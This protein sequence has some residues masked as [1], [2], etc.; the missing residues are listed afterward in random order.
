MAETINNIEQN[1][2][3]V[4]VS[5]IK[6]ILEKLYN[7]LPF[8]KNNDGSIVQ[9]DKDGNTTNIT[10]N[11]GEIALGKYNLSDINTVLSLGIG[12]DGNRK[13]AIQINRN[14]EIFIITDFNTFDT[15]SLQEIISSKG[16]SF[17]SSYDEMMLYT[18][19]KRYTGKLLYL[20]EDSIYNEVTYKTGLYIVSF[21][22]KE[23]SLILTNIASSIESVL[24]NY[25]TKD[26]VDLII[27]KVNAGDIDL[28]NYYNKTEIDLMIDNLSERLTIVETWKEKPITDEDLE[29]IINK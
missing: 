8:R 24:S 27:D 17:C 29:N 23:N 5:F 20:T 21:S 14:G 28:L 9:I 16:V 11:A 12:E 6:G 13:N 7:W 1:D 2:K 18:N 4:R 15:D 26:Q 10:T 3:L 19:N 22:T 25:Y